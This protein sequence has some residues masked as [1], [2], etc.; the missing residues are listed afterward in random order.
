MRQ[1][2]L[3]SEQ[4]SSELAGPGSSQICLTS[5]I[6]EGSLIVFQGEESTEFTNT[7]GE[8]IRVKVCP[9]IEETSL[10][11]SRVLDG[12]QV[13]IDFNRGRLL[14]LQNNDHTF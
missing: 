13:S 7:L 8:K 5:F 4:S 1:K 10:L 3:R 9:T 12:R 6:K 11:L 14:I 2:L